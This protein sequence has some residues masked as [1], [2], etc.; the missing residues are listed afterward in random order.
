MK[1]ATIIVAVICAAAAMFAS[2]TPKLSD[3]KQPAGI[4]KTDVDSASFMMGY[5]FGMT[6]KQSNLG[7]LDVKQ[8]LKGMQAAYDGKEVDY[9][10]FQN[11]M[12]GFQE[13]RMTAIATE[14][15]EK[16][17]K[18]FAEN[19]SKE[20]VVTTESGIQYKVIREG[21]GV[22][23]ASMDT[24]EVNYEGKNLKG[25]VFDSSYDRGE[26]TTF[27][28]NGVIPGWTEGLQYVSEG[29]EIMLWIP[30]ELAYG[31]RGAAGGMIGPGEALTFR[32]ELLSVKPFVEAEPAK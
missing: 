6:M 32:V 10:E 15:E 23:P 20:G 14:N 30:A 26:S 22:K 1:K 24:V 29:G 8:I 27:P 2:C 31:A 28:L 18:F 19:G 21:N 25:E 4:S 17:A 12:S 5:S 11:I 13:K 7:P 3:E 9:M 16:S